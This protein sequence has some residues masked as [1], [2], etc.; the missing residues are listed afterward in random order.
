MSEDLKIFGDVVNL[1][2]YS[3]K[4]DD[5][6]IPTGDI[7]NLQ[8]DQDIR[9]SSLNAHFEF[10][11]TFDVHNNSQVD[12]DST[13]VITI[14]FRDISGLPY[15]RTFNIVSKSFSQYSERFRRTSLT[16][17]DSVTYKLSNIYDDVYFTGDLVTS[18][19]GYINDQCSGILENDNVTVEGT[20]NSE[21][22][23]SFLFNANRS[24]YTNIVSKLAKFNLRICQ[25]RQNIFIKEIIPS[26]LSTYEYVFTD[27]TI[28]SEYMYKIHDKQ[29]AHNPVGNLPDYE[30]YK[31]EMKNVNS[32]T[33]SIDELKP[34]LNLNTNVKSTRL[35]NGAKSQGATA[36]LSDGEKRMELFDKYMYQNTVLIVVPGTIEA[37]V[38][39]SVINVNLKGTVGL[40]D[41]G[42]EGDTAA[43]GKY[44]ICSVSDKFIGSKFIQRLQIS[45]L[46]DIAIR[47][48]K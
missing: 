27:N 29:F 3:I 5:Y 12:F 33:S 4:I 35:S 13:N 20:P 2:Y 30:L 43:S 6:E 28:N 23:G 48:L 1:N 18:V 26:E 44:Y 11:D 24:M 25:S 21:S 9:F 14:S 8:I 32:K 10:K 45:R 47:N 16:L 38:I 42:L 22:N 40:T 37:G 41:I 36:T 15:L 31:I 34:Q 7:L 39:D 17:V 19:V 46:D